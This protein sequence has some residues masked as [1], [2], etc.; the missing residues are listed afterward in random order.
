[1]KRS[2]S[3]VL[4]IVLLAM[5]GFSQSLNFITFGDWG[6]DGKY[7]QQETANAVGTYATNNNTKFVLVLGDN[8]YPRGV[9]STSDDHWKT[10]FED[11]Y[12]APSLQIPWYVTIGNHDYGGN[13]QAQIDYS[14]LSTRWKLPS[15]YYSFTQKIDKGT[16]A[17]FVIIDSNPFI[18]SYLDI[19]KNGELD[20]NSVIE[21]KAQDTEAQLRWM[22]SVLSTSNAKW[23]IVAAHHPAYSGGDH[24]N[25]QEIIDLVDPILVKNKVNLYLAGHDHDMQHLKAGNS[26]VNYFVSG[27][28]S[29]LRTTGYA[30]N[31]LFALCQNGFLSITISSESIMCS[32]VGIDGSILYVYEVK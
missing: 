10:S 29:K 2:F 22:D 31:T 19:G 11:V 16:D 12:T 20:S 5:N 8:F 32:F 17:L 7:G 28:A 26:E 14:S 6:R 9:K 21:L 27:A 13:V 18:K 24:G 4:F 3:T 15:R 1:M 30:E 25:N 23:K